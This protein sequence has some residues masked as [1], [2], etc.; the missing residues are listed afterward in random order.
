MR[1]T[2]NG[3]DRTVLEEERRLM[4]E[5]SSQRMSWS[6]LGKMIRLNALIHASMSYGGGY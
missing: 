3:Y 5:I 2:N 4:R 1:P 6:K